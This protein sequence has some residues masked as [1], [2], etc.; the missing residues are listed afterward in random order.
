[1]TFMSLLGRKRAQKLCFGVRKGRIW[2]EVSADLG[3]RTLGN[4]FED[5]TIQ[6]QGE[7]HSSEATSER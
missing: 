3:V 4:P 6:L 2:A 5:V 7:G 1:M